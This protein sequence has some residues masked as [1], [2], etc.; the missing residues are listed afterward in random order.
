MALMLVVMMAMIILFLI[1]L[2][3]YRRK[4]LGW[5]LSSR[6]TFGDRLP[7][8]FIQFPPVQPDA[9]AL[10]T[11]IDFDPLSFGQVQGNFTHRTVHGLPPSLKIFW[12]GSLVQG[13]GR[14]GKK[15]IGGPGVEDRLLPR[16]LYPARRKPSKQG[17]HLSPGRERTAR[18]AIF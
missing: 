8:Y 16:I 15:I 3:R 18:K 4:I 2:F 5:V 14:T 1:G 10:G 12:L 6:G 7:Y 17:S 13:N 9:A 11:I